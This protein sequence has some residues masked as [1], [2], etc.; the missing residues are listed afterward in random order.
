MKTSDK[1]VAVGNRFEK[2]C[3]LHLATPVVLPTSGLAHEVASL[4]YKHL[5]LLMGMNIEL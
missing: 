1:S 3:M 4:L 2:L 5:A